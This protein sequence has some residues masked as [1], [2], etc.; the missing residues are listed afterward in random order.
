ML[1]TKLEGSASVIKEQQLFS[2]YANCS[3]D[4]LHWHRH[5]I[6]GLHEIYNIL[7][8]IP[9]HGN[10]QKRRTMFGGYLFIYCC[11]KYHTF[12]QICEKAS[13]LKD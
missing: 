10:P 12:H 5:H 7:Q 1:K 2:G 6:S 3:R 13:Q 9:G 4:L 11:V 8:V